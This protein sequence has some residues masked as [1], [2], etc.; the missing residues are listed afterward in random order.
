M[1][2]TTSTLHVSVPLTDLA[3]A[4]RPDE[5]GY[6]WN[7]LLPQ[8][9]V[10]KRTD[11]IRQI[12]KGQLLREY[13]LRAGKGGRVQEVQFKVDPNQSFNA[14][15]Y[16]VQAIMRNT[17]AME[18]DEI[19]EY[20][21]EQMYACLIAMHT[22]MEIVTLRDTLRNTAFMTQN[23]T[24]TA[25]D[26]W[27]DY[28]SIVSDPID[29]LK[30]GILSV[31]TKTGHMP[32][33]IV[34]HAYV[35]DRIQRHPKVL[36]RG[37]VNPSGNAIVTIPMME[38]ILGVAPG[39]IHVT[40]QQWNEALEDQTPVFRAQIGPDT[41]IAYTTAPSIRSYGLGYSF[42]FQDASAGGDP[43]IIKE[44]E[45]P[46]VVYEFPDN[47]L[48]DPRGATIHRLVG[49]LDQK[50]LVSDAGYLIKNCVDYTNT[51]RYGTLLG[52]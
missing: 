14:V 45:A 9:I 2:F 30:V 16:A 15:D 42:M 23:V 46:F 48:F 10:R 44:I 21:Q 39:T 1:A 7:K 3:V 35:W 38:A 37:A 19:L 12:S 4:F 26:Y 47:G 33:M 6:L 43:Q 41:I 20:T 29:D 49:G 32:N 8:K 34:F 5:N 51:A 28:T 22:N 36:A 24:L 11:L 27:D 40:A 25:P 50:V 31:F 18:A 17:E 52:G 13:D